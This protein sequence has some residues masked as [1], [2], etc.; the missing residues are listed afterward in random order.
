MKRAYADIPGAQVH[1]VTEGSDEPLIL[2]HE[3]PRSWRTYTRLIP[4][5]AKTHRVIAMDTLGFNAA[6]SNRI[7]VSCG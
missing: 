5:L 1:Y 3:S 2:L 6:Q 7:L 4:L